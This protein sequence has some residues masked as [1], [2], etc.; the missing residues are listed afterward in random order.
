MSDHISSNSISHSCSRLLLASSGIVMALGA[1]LTV[2]ISAAEASEMTMYECSPEGDI[3]YEVEVSWVDGNS[4]ARISPES[5]YV[6]AAE[7]AAKTETAR[8][9]RVASGFSFES[10]NF[11][12]FGKGTDT[13]LYFKRYPNEAA[14]PCTEQAASQTH[15]SGAV[16]G[17]ETMLGNAAARSLGG[18][19]RNGP[20]TNFGQAGS[21]REGAPVTVT[22]NTGV[23]YDGYDWF[24]IR[25]PVGP[26]YQW[27][28]IMCW[29]GRPI[30][31]MYG[32]CGAVLGG[33]DGASEQGGASGQGG[34]N[35]TGWMAFAIGHDD[36]FGHGAGASRDEAQS[37]AM[38]YCGD[39]SCGIADMTQAQCHALASGSGGHWF[40]AGVSKQAAES[41]AMGFCANAGAVCTVRYSFCQ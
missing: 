18:R 21:L 15:A 3:Y 23:R 10:R 5:E 30:A 37:Y 25:Q 11:R 33:Q 31:G 40:G 1:M 6:S 38:Q 2:P 12:F 17:N 13:R 16:G 22:M 4:T 8:E 27:G 28:G 9:Q 35:G 14:V 34:S 29:E 24:E 39:A 32:E 19:L 41:F 26:A 20:G 36:L 7:S